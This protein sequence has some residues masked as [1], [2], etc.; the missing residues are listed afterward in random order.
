MKWETGYTGTSNYSIQSQRRVPDWSHSICHLTAVD[1]DSYT[2]FINELVFYNISP[3]PLTYSAEWVGSKQMGYSIKI[4]F[5]YELRLLRAQLS[6]QGQYV[7]GEE[8]G[9]ATTPEYTRI[10][11]Y[12]DLHYLILKQ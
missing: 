5:K 4:S 12:D 6:P 11:T 10:L 9:E 7:P 3:L 2:F 8:I 1:V